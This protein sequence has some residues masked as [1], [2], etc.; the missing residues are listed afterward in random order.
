VGHLA[1]CGGWRPFEL[2]GCQEVGFAV[3]D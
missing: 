3:E 1:L 2:V